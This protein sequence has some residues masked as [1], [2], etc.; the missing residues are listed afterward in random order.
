MARPR[1]AGNGKGIRAPDDDAD[2]GR[3][4]ACFAG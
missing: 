1:I 3:S 2:R 4:S